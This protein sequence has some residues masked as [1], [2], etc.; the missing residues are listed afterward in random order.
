MTNKKMSGAIDAIMP[1]QTK[2]SLQADSL[3]LKPSI[4]GG[5]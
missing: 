5:N 2:R 4:D 1:A 3:A